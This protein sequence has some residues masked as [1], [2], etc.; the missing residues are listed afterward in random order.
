VKRARFIAEAR[1]EFLAEIRFYNEKQEN[2]GARFAAAVEEAT[3]RA[4]IYPFAGSLSEVTDTRRVMLKGFPFALHYRP[5]QD[6]ILILAVANHLRRP[7]YWQKR[8]TK[9]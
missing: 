1:L 3:A 2:L 7:D 9:S 4:L 6:G 8:T 5:E